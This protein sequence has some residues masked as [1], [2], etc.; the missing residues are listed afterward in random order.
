MQSEVAVFVANSAAAITDQWVT[1]GTAAGTY[2]LTSGGKFCRHA[3][4]GGQSTCC[5]SNG[6]SCRYGRID[7]VDPLFLGVTSTGNS[8][9]SFAGPGPAAVQRGFRKR[10]V[11]KPDGCGAC[12][13]DRR[14]NGPKTQLLSVRGR[15]I[16]AASQSRCSVKT[17]GPF[18]S[19][20]EAVAW[21]LHFGIVEQARQPPEHVTRK[22]ESPKEVH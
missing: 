18:A 10:D 14:R 22:Y 5:D 2:E 8:V 3:V 15:Q 1:D 9:V 4:D 6:Q 21:W 12:I 19:V 20:G 13:S 7:P 17:R 16:A 11:G